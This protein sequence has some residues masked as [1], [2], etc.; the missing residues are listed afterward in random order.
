MNKL[1]ILLNEKRIS[2]WAYYYCRNINDDPEVRKYITD[3]NWAYYYCKD[4]EDYP[5]IR[6][7]ITD[8]FW[9]S[10]YCWN[11][12]KND[13]RLLKLAKKSGYKP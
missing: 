2:E 6:K 1:P 8:S 5:E 9:A 11:I 10:M 7:Y 12:N 3:P 4:V 13:E